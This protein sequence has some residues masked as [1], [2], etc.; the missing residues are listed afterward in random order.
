MDRYPTIDGCHAVWVAMT[1]RPD[2]LARSNG[3]ARV[4]SSPPVN[5]ARNPLEPPRPPRAAPR[6]AL[7]HASPGVCVL[8]TVGATDSADADKRGRL[9]AAAAAEATVATGGADVSLK[10]GLAADVANLAAA[11]SVGGE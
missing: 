3:R 10:I 2:R 1:R 9:A 11:S 5:L 8:P 7:S 4:G 6:L